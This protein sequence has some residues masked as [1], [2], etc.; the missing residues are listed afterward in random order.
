LQA[1]GRH[2][3]PRGWAFVVAGALVVALAV[4]SS[5]RDDRMKM[6]DEEE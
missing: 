5:L 6:N 3:A 2:G 4:G 1:T